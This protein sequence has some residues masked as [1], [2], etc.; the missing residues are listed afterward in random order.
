MRGQVLEVY[1]QQLMEAHGIES[2]M[3]FNRLKARVLDGLSEV[4][5]DII[6]HDAYVNPTPTP[7]H[8]L[9]ALRHTASPLSPMQC[10]V[11]NQY[12]TFI[13]TNSCKNVVMAT[14]SPSHP[15]SNTTLFSCRF[16]SCEISPILFRFV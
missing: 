9:P 12:D 1:R 7:P 3:E 16:S 2:H 11:G 6:A 13:S 15:V 4:L 5:P 14:S 8:P 10:A